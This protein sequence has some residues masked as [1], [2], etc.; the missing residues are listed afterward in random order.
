MGNVIKFLLTQST[1]MKSNPF[2]LGI[3]LLTFRSI[4]N[5]NFATIPFTLIEFS[6]TFHNFLPKVLLT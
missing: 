6:T 2:P 5:C 1:Q 4:S 3:E